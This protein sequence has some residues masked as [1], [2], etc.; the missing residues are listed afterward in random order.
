MTM[1]AIL[2][3]SFAIT[4]ATSAR[5]QDLSAP[6]TMEAPASHSEGIR[7]AETSNG[8]QLVEHGLWRS[9]RDGPASV[10]T[11]P[12]NGRVNLP[13]RYEPETKRGPSD[14]RRASYLP[15]IYAAE[16]KYSLPAGLLD[17][18]VWTESRYNPFAVSPAGAAGLGQLM[19]ATAKELGV[20]NRFDPMANIFGAARYLRQMLDRFGVVHL[21]VAAYNAGPGAVERAG[22]I[23]RNGETPGYVR[24]VLR[25]WQF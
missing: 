11:V 18:L 15:H 5:A 9:T 21:A 23:P 10:L 7:I 12:H 14:F 1:K 4:S 16:A 24:D 8:F 17:A 2:V 20:F 25:H 6:A 13:Y 19:P 3:A 22:G